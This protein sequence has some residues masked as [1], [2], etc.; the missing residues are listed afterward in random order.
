MSSTSLRQTPTERS[1]RD[2]ANTFAQQY[3]RFRQN[4]D[5]AKIRQAQAL[6]RSQLTRL[7]SQPGTAAE[8]RSLAGRE[9]QL[10][11]LAALQTGNAELVQAALPPRSA[12]SPKPLRNSLIGLVVGLGLGLLLAGFFDRR[13]RTLREADEVEDIFG[14]PLIGSVIDSR[15]FAAREAAPLPPS[16]AESFRLLRANLR[17]FNL[18]RALQTFLVTSPGPSEGKSTVAFNLGTTYARAGEKTLVIEADLRNPGLPQ[19]GLERHLSR[20]WSQ[21]GS[22]GGGIVSRRS[23][24]CSYLSI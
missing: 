24:V 13:D 11:I 8:R 16:E 9:S 14:R 6:V 19:G 15:A 5:R 3:V 10:E 1:Q 20:A 2:F 21:L 4:A 17:Y 22:R 23:R 7:E 18:K 12:S